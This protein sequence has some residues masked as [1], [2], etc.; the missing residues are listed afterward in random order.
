MFKLQKENII[1]IVDS[2]LK[3]NKLINLGFALVQTPIDLKEE[4]EEVNFETMNK[5]ELLELAKEKEIE[6]YSTMN[7]T[8]L[9]NALKG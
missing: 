1:K 8:E 6:G 4:K 5:K 9:V 2:S 3:C 7:K